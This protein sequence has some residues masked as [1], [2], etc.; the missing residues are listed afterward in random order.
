MPPQSP[1]DSRP[2]GPRRVIQKIWADK[3]LRDE[4]IAHVEAAIGAAEAWSGNLHVDVRE[5]GTFEI[6]L[7]GCA[8]TRSI[9]RISSSSLIQLHEK[10]S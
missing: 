10:A 2:K 1:L 5:S 9:R 3:E 4:F 7:Q 8:G 6:T